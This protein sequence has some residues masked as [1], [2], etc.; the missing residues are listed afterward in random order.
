MFFFLESQ[1]WKLISYKSEDNSVSG[2]RKRGGR[3]LGGEPLI[4]RIRYFFSLLCLLINMTLTI[5]SIIVTVYVLAIFVYCLQS[6]ILTL[7]FML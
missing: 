2:A 1:L 3:L 5:V 6:I 7:L 4:G